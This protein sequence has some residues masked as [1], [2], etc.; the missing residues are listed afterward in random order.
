MDFSI[1]R[2]YIIETQV[3]FEHVCTMTGTNLNIK[4]LPQKSQK[5]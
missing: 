4:F 5:V 2:L 1:Y 3:Q